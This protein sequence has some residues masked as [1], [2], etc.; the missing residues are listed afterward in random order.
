LDYLYW[1]FGSPNEVSRKFK[2][3]SSLAISAFDYANYLL[4]YKGFCANIVLNYYRREP[5]RS[6]ELVFEDETW[7]VDLLKNQVTCKDQ[8]LFSSEQQISD[9]YQVQMKYFIN[10]FKDKNESINSINDAFNVLKIC[11]GNDTKE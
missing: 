3:Q 2:S 11:M 10:C 1:L 5:K 8:I 7:N 9:T 4:D 6:L